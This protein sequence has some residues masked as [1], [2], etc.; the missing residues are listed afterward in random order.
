MLLST[1]KAAF[2][3]NLTKE[4]VRNTNSLNTG[5]KGRNGETDLH[6]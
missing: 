6:L 4:A 5:A 2:A 3:L 1:V